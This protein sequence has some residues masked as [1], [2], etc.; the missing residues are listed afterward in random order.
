MRSKI[1]LGFLSGI[2]CTILVPASPVIAE[3]TIRC[4]SKDREYAYCRVKTHNRVELV[5]QN[6][7]TRCRQ[8]R[9]WG[10]D[11]HGVWVDRGCEATFR[12]G[13]RDQDRYSSGGTKTIRCKSRDGQYRYCRAKTDNRVSLVRQYSETRC[14][15]GRNWD[16]DRNGVWVDDGCE[17]EFRVGRRG[18]DHG[19]HDNDDDNDKAVVAGAALA[20][21]AIVAALSS[22]EDKHTADVPSWAVG[23]FYGYDEVEDKELKLTVLPGGAVKGYA[24]RHKFTG[25][26]EGDNLETGRHRFTVNRSGNGFTATDVTDA[27][28][29]IRFRR[30]GPGY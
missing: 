23:T 6:S 2:V 22:N 19:S 27:G 7:Q 14:R 18:R 4:K 13:R 17:A 28:H 29:R 8:G 3:Q 24:N 11:R 20:G 1:F 12:V 25:S 26:L 16:F 5:R 21:L 30:D 9:N 15:K 10:Y